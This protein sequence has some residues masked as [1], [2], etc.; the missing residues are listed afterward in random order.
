MSLRKK[1]LLLLF[2][3]S[4]SALHAQNW[5]FQKYPRL[6]AD[7]NHMD[8][9]IR[10]SE[11]GSI[12]GDIRYSGTMR[13]SRTDSI[14]FHAI[15]MNIISVAVNGQYNE[16]R[17]DDDKF[18]IMLNQTLSRGQSVTIRIQYDTEPGF[19][20]HVNSNGTIWTSFLPKT[21]RH[22]LPVIDHPRIA[23]TSEI[24]YTYPAGKTMV[25]SG[26]RGNSELLSVDEEITTFSSTRP[27]PVSALRWAVG[28][29]PE[30]ISTTSQ[31]SGFAAF[32]RRSDPQ[33]YM[34]SESDTNSSELLGVAADAF[35]RV[36]RELGAEFP[37][38]DLHIV[39]LDEDHWETKNY[40]AGVI[41]A[42][43][44]DNNIVQ[45][46]QKGILAQWIGTHIREEQWSDAAAIHILQALYAN[47][48]FNFELTASAEAEPYHIFSDGKLSAWQ[49]FLQQQNTGHFAD[50]AVLTV[51]DMLR[52]S[53][54]TL[55][56]HDFAKLIYDKTGQPYFS[57]FVL[58]EPDIIEFPRDSY[59][60]TARIVW[61]EGSG[62]AEIHFEAIGRPIDELVT[63]RVTEV[64]FTDT[65]SHEVTFSG[66]SDGMVI[67]TSRGVENLILYI[68]NRD[69]ITLHV[70]KPY[71]FWV[72]QLRND[73]NPSRRADAARGLS[74][75]TENP[76]LQLALN[77][78]LQSETDSDVIAE[79]LRSISRITSGAAG[80]DERFI[81]YTSFQ[82]PQSVQLAATQAL[83]SFSNNERVISRLRTIIIQT[84]S[85]DIR[86]EA[87]YS[88]GEVADEERFQNYTE[89]FVT[90][91]N[92][93]NE[94]PLLL[95]LLA[96]KGGAEAAIDIASTFISQ[97][98]PFDI[99]YR[100]LDVMLEYDRSP[101]NWNNRLPD[102]LSDRHPRIRYKAAQSLDR[103]NP[104]Q[105]LRI[106]EQR[107]DDEYD[108]RVKMMLR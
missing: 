30:I 82:Q 63:V 38:R 31:P 19:G 40:G 90:R 32:Q 67:N 72:H 16:Y 78:L 6:Q 37:Y 55:S 24:A 44:M 15:G 5:D 14:Q 73:N 69:D 104:Q 61:E 47:R 92:V 18:V 27:V 23:F 41:V 98:F 93:L 52:Q 49:N 87:I 45:Q 68:D 13:Q 3:I 106:V 8:A 66:Q 97:E 101:V 9:E 99:R 91:E 56:W 33:I 88:L 79:I 20:V 65:R 2:L 57:G 75:Y 81:Q 51:S 58:D 21:T 76:D 77:D 71:L 100:V 62:T 83:A 84:N 29:F 39:I 60:Y 43:G 17:A 42:S 105:R 94:V 36:Q 11:D 74:L 103:L 53:G 80:T 59:D 89:D 70:E 96:E 85:R 7:I 10:I 64:T 25:A 28:D 34:Y 107:Y 50:D 12:K 46:I 48:L 4:S 86:R 95:R 35:Q 1:F 22:W 26:R 102:L 108:E 54:Q